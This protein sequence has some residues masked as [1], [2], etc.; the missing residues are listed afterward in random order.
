MRSEARLG[1]VETRR[2][3]ARTRSDAPAFRSAAISCR[4]AGSAVDGLPQVVRPS[5]VIRTEGPWHARNTTA[6][7]MRASVVRDGEWEPE[8]HATQNNAIN[9]QGPTVSIDIAARV[10]AASFALLDGP[11]LW[12][13]NRAAPMHLMRSPIRHRQARWW[14]RL[15]RKRSLSTTEP[16]VVSGSRRLLTRQI[17]PPTLCRHRLNVSS[18]ILPP[19]PCQRRRVGSPDRSTETTCRSSAG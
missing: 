1:N 5:A 4:A 19:P 8:L 3:A 15:L 16:L 18:A 17:R 7:E 10:R 13:L 9:V 12:I 2:A 11:S 6:A 14:G